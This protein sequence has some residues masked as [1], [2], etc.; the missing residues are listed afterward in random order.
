MRVK[1]YVCYFLRE[2]SVG[3][4]APAF[5]CLSAGIEVY[6]RFSLTLEIYHSKICFVALQHLCDNCDNMCNKFDS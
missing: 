2:Q 3:K 1:L 4:P 6:K 5:C